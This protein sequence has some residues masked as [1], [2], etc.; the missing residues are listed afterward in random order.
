[1]SKFNVRRIFK[2]DSTRRKRLTGAQTALF[3]PAMPAAFALLE[4]VGP[5]S[6]H[7]G[8]PINPANVAG[9]T[10]VTSGGTFRM[11]TQNL[12]V[13]PDATNQAIVGSSLGGAT[14]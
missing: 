12:T 10:S 6:F 1:M 13:I 3:L 5:V 9:T 8:D 7:V 14:L 2:T 11:H 4:R